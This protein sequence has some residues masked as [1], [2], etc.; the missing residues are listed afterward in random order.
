[1]SISTPQRPWVLYVIV[2]MLLVALTPLFLSSQGAPTTFGS[3]Q[4]IEYDGFTLPPTEELRGKEVVRVGVYILSVGNLDTKTGTYMVDFFL[5]LQC[6]DPGNC[7]PNDFDIMNAAEIKRLDRQTTEDDIAAGKYFYRIRANLQTNLNLR[8]FPF[9]QHLLAIE[10]EDKN[11]NRDKYIFIADPELSGIDSEVYVAGWNLRP[12][13][14]GIEQVH[15]YP[16]YEE[17]Y[18]RVQFAIRIFHTWQSSF[19]KGLFA[20]I[21]IVGAGMLSFLLKEN[22]ARDRITLTS[23]TLASSIFYHMTLTASVPPVG[24]L[25]YADRFMILNYVFIATQLVVAISLFLMQRPENDTPEI[26]QVAS[27]LHTTTRWLIPGGWIAALITLHVTT[28]V[29]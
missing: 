5:N 1:M 15:D 14:R 10:L 12:Y 11:K 24:Y 21:V 3:D 7:N 18:S 19:M 8:D 22:E 25:T 9:D 4:K 17:Q 28:F 16:I 6:E 27:Q 29:R 23:S 26:K 13:I 2:F 20:A